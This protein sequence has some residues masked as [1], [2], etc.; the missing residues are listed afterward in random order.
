M[1]LSRGCPRCQPRGGWATRPARVFESTSCR[2]LLVRN[3]NRLRALLLILVRTV[4]Y[5]VYSVAAGH[6]SASRRSAGSARGDTPTCPRNAAAA[7]CEHARFELRNQ[8]QPEPPPSPPVRL[9]PEYLSW[10]EDMDDLLANM[11]SVTQ[12]ALDTVR[13]PTCMVG[14]R[15]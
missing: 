4:S 2:R 3:R 6:G 7:R 15:S 13:V 11:Q 10:L 5:R 1:A 9:N 14:W 12:D 8:P